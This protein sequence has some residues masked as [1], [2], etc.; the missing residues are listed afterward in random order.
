MCVSACLCMYTCPPHSLDVESHLA[1]QLGAPENLGWCEGVP[2]LAPIPFSSSFHSDSK[3]QKVSVGLEPRKH[4][5]SHLFTTHLPDDHRQ[6]QGDLS[7]LDCVFPTLLQH[8][9]LCK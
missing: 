7:E 8:W 5:S 3:P 2:H 4:L 6:A 9:A 1:I